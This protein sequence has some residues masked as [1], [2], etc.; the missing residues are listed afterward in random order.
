ML[1]AAAAESKC[2]KQRLKPLNAS[3][4]LFRFFFFAY[5]MIA[6]E[7][8]FA[9]ASKFVIDNDRAA[10]LPY[11]KEIERIIALEDVLNVTM[12]ARSELET[13]DFGVELISNDPFNLGKKIVDGLRDVKSIGVDN[14]LTYLFTR[15][16]H[17]EMNVY[18]NTRIFCT[19]KSTGI[20]M[21]Q[22]LLKMLPNHKLRGYSDAAVNCPTSIYYI[23]I[24]LRD[25]YN[26]GKSKSWPELLETLLPLLSDYSD[27]IAAAK[28]S[29][30]AP[31]RGGA[32]DPALASL[33]ALPGFIWVDENRKQFVTSATESAVKAAIG[34]VNVETRR[35]TIFIPD[36]MLLEKYS[37]SRGD[38]K[39]YEYYNS[40]AYEI[41]PVAG[42]APPMMSILPR[43]RFYFINLWTL[44]MLNKI[45]PMQGYEQLRQ[46][47]IGEITPLIREIKKNEKTN[48]QALFPRDYIGDALDETAVKQKMIKETGERF[49]PYF[50]AAPAD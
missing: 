11:Y 10:Y 6:E 1:D 21:R 30:K 38:Q 2:L 37:I 35:N 15:I 22:P 20:V 50:A 23:L 7:S 34:G 3:A 41:I 27:A 16:R 47:R 46:R 24:K 28:L 17:K 8:L 40:T 12:G 5:I 31:R 43:L 4:A 19:I 33:E 49:A 39:L 42:S 45:S 25:L 29:A 32:Q 36:D 26:P 13:L 9:E 48:P 14:K 18:I 44:E